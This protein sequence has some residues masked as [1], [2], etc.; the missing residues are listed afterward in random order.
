MKNYYRYGLKIWKIILITNMCNLLMMIH[1]IINIVFYLWNVKNNL[2]H[3]LLVHKTIRA[4]RFSK[5]QNILPMT[6]TK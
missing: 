1:Q 5:T 6:K 3:I 4:L 2:K